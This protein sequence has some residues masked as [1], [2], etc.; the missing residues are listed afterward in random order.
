MS[1]WCLVFTHQ[2]SCSIPLSR[3]TW[4][5][6]KHP[7]FRSLFSH[8]FKQ[9]ARSECNPFAEPV[10]Q[11]EH[12][13]CF[14]LSLLNEPLTFRLYFKNYNFDYFCFLTQKVRIPVRTCQLKS[15]IG[16]I[17]RPPTAQILT[18]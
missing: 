8:T 6:R 2:L 9:S 13:N 5:K 17:H 11:Q 7:L 14:F 16:R 15:N 18:Q 4:G 12:F 10:C 3:Y 1:C